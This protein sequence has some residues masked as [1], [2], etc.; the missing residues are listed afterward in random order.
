MTVTGKQLNRALRCRVTPKVVDM[1]AVVD[2]EVLMGDFWLKRL[3]NPLQAVS[4]RP[5]RPSSIRIRERI[6]RLLHLYS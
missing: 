6:Q 5:C 4:N 2:C 1:N 3:T